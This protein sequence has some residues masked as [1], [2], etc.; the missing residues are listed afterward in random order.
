MTLNN[1]QVSQTSCH[2]YRYKHLLQ[3]AALSSWYSLITAWW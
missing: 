2:D 3:N 1:E